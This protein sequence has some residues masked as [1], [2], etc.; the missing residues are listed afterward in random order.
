MSELVVSSEP[1]APRSDN[2]PTQAAAPLGRVRAIAPVGDR[3][4]GCVRRVR[5]LMALGFCPES[6]ASELKASP[7]LVW[8]VALTAPTSMTPQ[9]QS[10]II[11]VYDNLARRPE[12]ISGPVSKR[13]ALRDFASRSGWRT[14]AVWIDIDDD[15]DAATAA[16]GA[17][18]AAVRRATELEAENASLAAAAA[19]ANRAV[20]VATRATDAARRATDRLREDMRAK[21]RLARER[22]DG[23]A[24][25]IRRLGVE[26]E[27]VRAEG[28][29]VEGELFVKIDELAAAKSD[30][31]T[32]R[33]EVRALRLVGAA[34]QLSLGGT[35][36]VGVLRRVDGG[37][38]VTAHVVVGGVGSARPFDLGAWSMEAAPDM[39]AVPLL[40]A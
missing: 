12:R 1:A 37:A 36:L 19:A 11:A 15:D 20:G 6:I 16:D 13:R 38:T 22:G 28:E 40:A 33:A 31:E 26:M 10:S 25:R 7:D 34:V 23:L 24:L 30:S 17:L 27:A 32:L 9:L 8:L 4:N 2:A 29:R 5:A 18:G 3:S 14:P 35:R 21:V 39:V